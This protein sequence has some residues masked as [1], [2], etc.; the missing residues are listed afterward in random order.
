M[1]IDKLGTYFVHFDIRKRF[2]IT[3]E[4]FV[5]LVKLGRWKEWISK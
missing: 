5:Q 2:N 4:Q 1:D 3:F